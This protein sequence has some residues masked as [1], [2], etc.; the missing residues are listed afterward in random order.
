MQRAVVGRFF[1]NTVDGTLRTMMWKAGRCSGTSVSGLAQGGRQLVQ[2]PS[3]G[4]QD[5]PCI[6]GSKESKEHLAWYSR[7]RAE[8]LAGAGCGGRS[9][10]HPVLHRCTL[11]PSSWQAHGSHFLNSSKV[12]AGAR[13]SSCDTQAQQRAGPR[14]ELRTEPGAS[15]GRRKGWRCSYHGL[16]TQKPFS[17]PLSLDFSY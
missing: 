14:A 13:F 7:H 9:H 2:L 6:T 11:R 12:D 4:Q 5:K 17:I 16:V 10:A 8:N 15:L 1:Q 3:Q